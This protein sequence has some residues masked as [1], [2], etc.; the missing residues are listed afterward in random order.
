[1]AATR[2]VAAS[3]ALVQRFVQSNHPG[4]DTV[5]LA[6]SAARGTATA[7]SDLDIV[8]LLAALPDGAW[9]ETRRFEGQLIEAFVHDLGT[10][11]HFSREIDAKSGT[12]ILPTMV[13]EGILLPGLP[14]TLAQAAKSLAQDVISAGPPAWTAE[15]LD[16]HRHLITDLAAD[17]AAPRSR[18]EAIAVGVRLYAE[19]AEFR[20]RAAGRWGAQG[21]AVPRALQQLSAEIAS[22]HEQGLS[23]LV[24]DQDGTM[25]LA[26]V[27]D[28]LAP[29]GG[30][31][32][33]GFRQQAPKNWRLPAL[34]RAGQRSSASS[35]PPPPAA[36][37]T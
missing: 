12:A 24:A 19:L 16:L 33:D 35:R 26:L 10:L 15:Q 13:V 34:G 20:L 6:G 31:L 25:M 32:D 27:D 37:P 21:K 4:A 7:S 2:E 23:R 9:R 36:T 30:R 8:V 29:Y 1:M 14:S 3:L 17:L 28:T 18:H 5:L 11:E 22:R